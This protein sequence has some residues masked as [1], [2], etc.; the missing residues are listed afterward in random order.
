MRALLMLALLGAIAAGR[1]EAQAQAARPEK[2]FSIPF[3]LDNGH[4][5]ISAYVNGHGPYRF[6]FD[7]GASGIGRADNRLRAELG[8]PLVDQ[9]SNSDG[10][11]VATADVVSAASLR[12]GGLEKRD[13]KLLARDYNG[14]RIPPAGPLMGIIARDFFADRLVTIDYPK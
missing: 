7:T 9:A 8:L 10:I 1:G 6:G 2:P 3:E 5:F 11:K 4:I 13:V 12:V 14:A